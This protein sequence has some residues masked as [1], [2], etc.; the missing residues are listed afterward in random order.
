MSAGK[1][2][3]GNVRK[4][5]WQ[6]ARRL[7]SVTMHAHVNRPI[8]VPFSA[9]AGRG[10]RRAEIGM[11]RS[12]AGLMRVTGSNRRVLVVDDNHYLRLLIMSFLEKSGFTQIAGAA[13]ALDAVRLAQE[14][15]FDVALIS[16]DLRPGC[17]YE[18]RA[19]LDSAAGDRAAPPAVLMVGTH[20]PPGARHWAES[21]F[22][23]RLAK[24]FSPQALLTALAAADR[25]AP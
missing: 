5:R 4:C 19:A 24:P 9:K 10:R 21:G 15:A 7:Y 2:Q 17:P 23:A 25:A 3:P 14:R 20:S 1:C 8:P 12:G 6:R 13:D 11:A 22:A 16:A 18:L